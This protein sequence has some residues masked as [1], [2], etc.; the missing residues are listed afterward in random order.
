[1]RSEVFT[2]VHV[3][4]PVFLAVALCSIVHFCQTLATVITSHL[5][6]TVGMVPGYGMDD[7]GVEVL[8]EARFFSSPLVLKSNQTP[9]RGSLPRGMAA[10][11]KAASIQL[12]P[13]SYSDNFT[14]Y[15][16]FTYLGRSHDFTIYEAFNFSDKYT[17]TNNFLALY[18]CNNNF[19][20]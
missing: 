2:A 4:V 14:F 6:S 1:M 12:G 20:D 13:K 16:Y 18:I 11:H 10:G 15:F 9:I 3:E 19:F 7:Q 8:I 17:Q 5:Y